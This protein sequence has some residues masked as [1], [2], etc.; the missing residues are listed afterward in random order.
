[1][2]TGHIAARYIPAAVALVAA[3]VFVAVVP[4]RPSTQVGAGSGSAFE[5]PDVAPDGP[6]GD[7]ADGASASADAVPGGTVASGGSGQ[8]SS[9]S[10]G[11]TV[12]GT[13]AGTAGGGGSASGAGS[14]GGGAVDCSRQ[15]L[16]GGPSCRPPKWSGNNGGATAPG[17]TGDSITIVT[18]VPKRNPQVQAIL[19]AAGTASSA[20]QINVLAAYE[21]FFNEQYELYGRKVKLLFQEGPGDGADPAQ[22]QADAAYIAT[23]LKAFYVNCSAC[24]GSFHDEL[25]RRGLP[26][27]TVIVPFTQAYHDKSAPYLF[28]VLP[29]FDLTAQSGADYYCKRLQGRKAV[30]AGDATFQAQNRK[31]GI[32]AVDTPENPGDAYKRYLERCGGEVAAVVKYASDITTAQQQATNAILQLRQSGAN[33]VT[34]VCDVIAP[35]FFTAAAT[36]QNYHPEWFQNGL[37]AQESYK[38]G[39]LYDQTQW[40]RAF[41]IGSI[42]KPEPLEQEEWYVAYKRGGGTDEEAIANAGG[43]IFSGLVQALDAIEAAGPNLTAQG[44]VNKMLTLPAYGGKEVGQSQQSFGKNGPGPWTRVDDHGEIWWNPSK[45]APNGRAGEQHYVDGGRRYK[46]GEWPRTD[47]KVFVDDGSPQ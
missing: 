8:A 26:S 7:A 36:Q 39:Q 35:V 22:N 44:F 15:K 6:G 14:G 3:A 38:A 34:C 25:V 41:G 18:Y 23:E 29:D 32:I 4:S 11:G 43:S 46:V 37:F 17:V 10:R 19:A 42:S 40:S 1:M 21:K 13:A 20:Q 47:P 28:G 24:A 30:H 5:L 16:I 45:P 27:T 31:L 33:I 9:A 2:S 12:G